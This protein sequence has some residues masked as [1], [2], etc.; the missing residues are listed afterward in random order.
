MKQSQTLQT[1]APRSPQRTWDENDGA[2]PLRT[3]FARRFVTGFVRK[4]RRMKFANATKFN[5]KCGAAKG[6]A[7]PRTIRGNIFSTKRNGMELRSMFDG[8]LGSLER[9]E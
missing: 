3:L 4:E 7:V 6:S 5:R 2:Q 1:G 8:V 9:D